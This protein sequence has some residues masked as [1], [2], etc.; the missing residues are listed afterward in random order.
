[1]FKTIRFLHQQQILSYSYEDWNSMCIFPWIISCLKLYAMEYYILNIVLHGSNIIDCVSL[2]LMR[3]YVESKHNNMRT[4]AN[5]WG[6]AGRWLADSS[7]RLPFVNT[8]VRLQAVDHIIYVC[9]MVFNIR[10]LLHLLMSFD[11]A[12]IAC[13]HAMALVTSFQHA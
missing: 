13:E 8:S 5:I 6:Y 7:L 3:L 12:I 9:M 2:G 1:M 11:E 10:L 4:V